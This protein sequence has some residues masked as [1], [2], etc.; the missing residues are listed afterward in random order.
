MHSIAK[1]K[2]PSVLGPISLELSLKSTTFSLE[3]E[4]LLALAVNCL[5]KENLMVLYPLLR[6]HKV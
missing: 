4:S 2:C 6:R 5:Q 1:Q 3:S